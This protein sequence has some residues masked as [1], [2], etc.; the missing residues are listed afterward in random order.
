[1]KRERGRERTREIEREKERG[2]QAGRQGERERER[3]RKSDS[4]DGRFFSRAARAHA[5]SL[6]VKQMRTNRSD[7]PSR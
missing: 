2:R 1:M 5:L 4:M 6:S 3:E 7:L